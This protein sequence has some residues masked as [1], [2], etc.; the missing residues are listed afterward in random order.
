M[1]PPPPAG[2]RGPSPASAGI[3]PGVRSID[4]APPPRLRD[5]RSGSSSSLASGASGSQYMSDGRSHSVGR[6]S[7]DEHRSGSGSGS[8]FG[9]SPLADPGIPV[10]AMARRPS[11]EANMAGAGAGGGRRPSEPYHQHQHQQG[12]G[13]TQALGLGLPSSQSYPNRLSVDRDRLPTSTSMRKIS[14][15]EGQ[16]RSHSRGS[17]E[18]PRVAGPR[19]SPGETTPTRPTRSSNRGS[20]P[21][22]PVI[23]QVQQ[24]QQPYIDVFEEESD[25]RTPRPPDIVPPPLGPPTITTTLPS[26]A[27]PTGSTLGVPGEPLS[28]GGLGGGGAKGRPQRRASFHPPPLDTAFSREVL[29]TSRTGALPGAAG[30]TLESDGEGGQDAAIMDSVEDVL[31]SFD[32]TVTNGTMDG[33][34]KKGSADAIENRLMDELSALDSVGHLSSLSAP[35]PRPS[36]KSLNRQLKYTTMQANIHAFLESDD[37]ISQVLGHIDEALLE[38]DDIDMQIT[39]YKMQLNVGRPRLF[40]ECK[41]GGTTDGTGCIGRHFLYRVA[42]PRSAGTNVEPASSSERDQAAPGT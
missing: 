30:L 18:I 32:W 39:S 25:P 31:E 1:A 7:L 11:G 36:G 41:A 2:G 26:P 8:A 21:G 35:L 24:P 17:G 5:H 20:S 27:I 16:S 9:R 6:P 4:L 33:S 28:A 37:R 19:P 14:S 22:G 10:P 38:L 40:R 13:Q 23:P 29:L 3:S 42:K 12:Q 34:R 15:S